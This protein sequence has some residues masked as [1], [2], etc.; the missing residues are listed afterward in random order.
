MT[1]QWRENLNTFN[2]PIKGSCRTFVSY[3]N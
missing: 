1:T 2:M 3:L